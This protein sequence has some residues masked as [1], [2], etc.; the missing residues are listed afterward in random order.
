MEIGDDLFNFTSAMGPL[1][2]EGPLRVL[3]LQLPPY[4]HRQAVRLP[5]IAPSST[6]KVPACNQADLQKLCV[7]S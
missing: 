2:V 4:L 3:V 1:D 5:N 6:P 7:W